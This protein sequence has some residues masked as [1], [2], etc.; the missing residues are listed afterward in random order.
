MNDQKSDEQV[1][2]RLRQLAAATP[3]PD[4]DHLE[5]RLLHAFAQQQ[6]ATAAMP[7][8][9]R[10]WQWA[11]AAVLVM[12]VVGLSNI[13]GRFGAIEMSVANDNSLLATYLSEFVALPGVAALPA[14][15][16]GRIVRIEV[17]VSELP[18]YGINV[19]PDST[20]SSVEAD[21]LVGQDGLAR[22]IRLGSSDLNP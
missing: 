19:V 20:Q 16:S 2:S 22:A 8:P 21:L 12:S 4:L 18:A 3:E 1:I 11:A 15:E 5:A 13:V 10:W 7:Q 17:A 14:L 9:S 6:S